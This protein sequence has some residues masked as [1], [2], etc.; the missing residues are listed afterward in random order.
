MDYDAIIVALHQ[1][2]DVQEGF[3]EETER[4]AAVL[5]AAVLERELRRFHLMR[6][7]N[8]DKIS[9][10]LFGK[11]G[12]LGAFGSQID[13]A[14]GLGYIT[15][16][17]RYDL[18]LI[19]DI[20]NTFAHNLWYTKKSDN[21]ENRVSFSHKDINPMAL[22][23]RCPAKLGVDA[24]QAN[25]SKQIAQSVVNFRD[26]GSTIIN[27]PRAR[28]EFTCIW[29]HTRFMGYIRTGLARQ[30]PIAYEW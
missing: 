28:Y 30:S 9:R 24:L 5:G 2:L 22:R 3:S 12:P 26:S 29:L 11:H 10:K 23:L 18:D 8:S 20:R 13:L 14:Y 4:G 27:D 6:L 21:T 17:V 16:D 1:L 19:R 25:N 7:V 15:K